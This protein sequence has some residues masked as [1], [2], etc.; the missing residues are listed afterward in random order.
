MPRARSLEPWSRLL[1]SKT[2]TYC[3]LPICAREI[4][5]AM[6]ASLS[7]NVTPITIQDKV[8]NSHLILIPSKCWNQLFFRLSCQP[9]GTRHWPFTHTLALLAGQANTTALHRPYEYIKL[10]PQLFHCW[11]RS[12]LRAHRRNPPGQSFK[13]SQSGRG[14]LDSVAGPFDHNMHRFGLHS[15]WFWY[16]LSSWQADTSTT[17]SFVLTCFSRSD[18][19]VLPKISTAHHSQYRLLR[20]C[21]LFGLNPCH[22]HDR[23]C[24]F[25]FKPDQQL[26]SGPFDQSQG[27]RSVFGHPLGSHS[28]GSLGKY[29]LGCHLVR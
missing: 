24:S 14:R 20:H 3:M 18:R 21:R 12:G 22:S 2:T 4:T 25:H 26:W 13:H 8:R 27:R 15:Y 9:F 23:H 7:L 6:V 19:H 28:D 11:Y 29:I 10:Y 17:R 1:G 5:Q 16:V